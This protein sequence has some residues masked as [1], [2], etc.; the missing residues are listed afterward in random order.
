M[1]RIV[2]QKSASKKYNSISILVLSRI[3][4]VLQAAAVLGAALFSEV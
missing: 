3:S 4:L 1:P 2:D